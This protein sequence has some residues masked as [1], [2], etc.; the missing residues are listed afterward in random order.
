ML[1]ETATAGDQDIS[2]ALNLLYFL[3]VHFN[4]MAFEFR[5]FHT[6]LGRALRHALCWERLEATFSESP[7][8]GFNDYGLYCVDVLL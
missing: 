4:F 6:L 3:L 2:K 7:G 5:I 8:N 1:R